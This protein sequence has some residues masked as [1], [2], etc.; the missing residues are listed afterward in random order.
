MEQ[1]FQLRELDHRIFIHN[2]CI[3]IHDILH[4]KYIKCINIQKYLNEMNIL[5][6]LLK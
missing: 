5:Y 3:N 2:L 4:Y 1:L 6:Q